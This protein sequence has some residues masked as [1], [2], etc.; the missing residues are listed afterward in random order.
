MPRH[1]S[2]SLSLIPVSSRL[3]SFIF[4][5]LMAILIHGDTADVSASL[6]LQLPSSTYA[7]PPSRLCFFCSISNIKFCSR[8]DSF[9]RMAYMRRKIQ[10]N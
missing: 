2:L 10:R 7:S 1:E 8:F 3:L 5:V 4:S 6:L 9:G